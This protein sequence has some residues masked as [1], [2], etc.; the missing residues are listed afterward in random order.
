M[1]PIRNSS[2]ARGSVPST[3]V[4]IIY[5]VPDS[6][7]LLLKDVRIRAGAGT[8]ATANIYAN[9][10][11]NNV[12]VN[13]ATLS[14][15]QDTPAFWSGWLALN[16]GHTILLAPSVAGVNYWLSGA[17]LPQVPGF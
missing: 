10:P 16:A 14:W 7:V 4:T 15:T 6:T 12:T 1:P 11:V 3:A 13:I 8:S 2:V 17:L 9:D 5:T